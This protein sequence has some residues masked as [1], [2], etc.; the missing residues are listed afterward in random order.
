MRAVSV[1]HPSLSL[2]RGEFQPQGRNE[3][4]TGT[5]RNG[6]RIPRTYINIPYTGPMATIFKTNPEKSPAARRSR[7]LLSLSITRAAR[8]GFRLINPAGATKPFA[9]A[10]KG[11]RGAV[12]RGLQ[13][14][15]TRSKDTARNP[16]RF[17]CHPTLSTLFACSRIHAKRR[18]PSCNLAP[19]CPSVE[20]L[21]PPRWFRSSWN[22]LPNLLWNLL[23]GTEPRLLSSPTSNREPRKGGTIPNFQ[24][25]P[26]PTPSRPLAVRVRACPRMS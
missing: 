13:R 5:T 20:S 2:S 21:F 4:R 10:S 12:A 11:E 17:V 23:S 22:G 19:P 15:A 16:K 3:S 9:H 24:L 8:N 7:N 18:V 1:R 6:V 26:P 14:E 25:N